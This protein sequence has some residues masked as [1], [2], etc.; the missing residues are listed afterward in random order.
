MEEGGGGAG[1]GGGAGVVDALA[2]FFE[3]ASHTRIHVSWS[4][5]LSV[6]PFIQFPKI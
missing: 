3:E 2:L 6:H 4:T 5:H 1:D